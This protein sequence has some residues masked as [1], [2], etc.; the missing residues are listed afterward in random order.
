MGLFVPQVNQVKTLDTSE[1]PLMLL[2]L[3]QEGGWIVITTMIEGCLFPIATFMRGGLTVSS[4]LLPS[5]F[6]VVITAGAYPCGL[7]MIVWTLQAMTIKCRLY[8][9]SLSLIS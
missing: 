6:V 9:G 5:N 3:W 2:S 1:S 8:Y 4:V 7:L